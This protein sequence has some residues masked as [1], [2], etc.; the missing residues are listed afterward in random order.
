LGTLFDST[1]HSSLDDVGIIAFYGDKAFVSAL[2]FSIHG[3][4]FEVREGQRTFKGHLQ[5]PFYRTFSM[6]LDFGSEKRDMKSKSR[7]L[8][9]LDHFFTNSSEVDSSCLKHWME[10]WRNRRPPAAVG[11]SRCDF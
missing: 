3:S 7:A 11:E 2:L 10:D 8:Y 4:R 6:A 9:R 5:Q 1:H